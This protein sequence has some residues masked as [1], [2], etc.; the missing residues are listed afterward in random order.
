MSDEPRSIPKTHAPLKAR[1]TFGS[2]FRSLPC[3]GLYPRFQFRV[4]SEHCREWGR[5]VA[6]CWRED[7]LRCMREKSPAWLGVLCAAVRA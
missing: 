1:L 5:I 4:N 7:E 6:F 3:Q 2:P